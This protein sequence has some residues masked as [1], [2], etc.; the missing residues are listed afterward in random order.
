MHTEL[1]N[2]K[3]STEV[4]VQFVPLTLPSSAVSAERRWGQYS[5][6][7][8]KRGLCGVQL[9][10]K[11]EAISGPVEVT[12]QRIQLQPPLWVEFL[13]GKCRKSS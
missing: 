2:N 12:Q 5:R 9:L 8:K 10:Y 6:D 7:G 11:E 1:L 3:V 4:N 13:A